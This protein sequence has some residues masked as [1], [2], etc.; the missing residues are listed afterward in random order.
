MQL[1]AGVNDGTFPFQKPISQE[2]IG[3]NSEHRKRIWKDIWVVKGHGFSIREA[4]C[5]LARKENE[6][7]EKQRKLRY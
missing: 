4:N 5:L 7:E 3:K 6:L 2:S 1:K